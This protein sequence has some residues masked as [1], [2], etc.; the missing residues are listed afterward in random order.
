MSESVL[1]ALVGVGGILVGGVVTAVVG[2]RIAWN[3]EKRK[4]L[5]QDRQSLIRICRQLIQTDRLL[6]DGSMTILE[7]LNYQIEFITLKP[8]LKPEVLE[9]LNTK[10]KGNAFDAL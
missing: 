5:R 7:A 9:A 1:V 3:I 10:E 2:P 4:L 8:F 6:F